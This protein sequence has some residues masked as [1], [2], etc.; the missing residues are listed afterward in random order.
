[1]GRIKTALV[2]RTA[3]ELMK[4]FEFTEDFEKNKEMRRG[5]LPS[6]KIRNMVA[7]YIARV[8]KRE[9]KK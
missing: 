8:K 4:R 3:E 9:K 7:G 2:K 1:M 5:V 6:K